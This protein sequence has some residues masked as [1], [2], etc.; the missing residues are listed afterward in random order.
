M[1]SEQ[2]IQ[3]AVQRV[4]E[5]ATPSRVIVFGSHARGEATER[6]DLDLLVVE[7]EVANVGEE[8][9]RLH[10]ALWPLNIPVDLLVCSESDFAK[11]REWR[12]SAIYWAA[13]EGR[14][15]YAA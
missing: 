15:M 11:K 5:V 4:V 6:S 10:K 7:P 1:I 3:Q 13:R 9:I 2:I 8:M 14:V 12:S